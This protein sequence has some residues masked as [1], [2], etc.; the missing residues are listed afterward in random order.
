[1]YNEI[2]FQGLG[3]SCARNITS[4]LAYSVFF[5][6]LFICTSVAVW[7]TSKNRKEG[8]SDKNSRE[9]ADSHFLSRNRTLIC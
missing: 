6:Y 9:V 3:G 1:M 2:D 8:E 5:P 7:V 4:L